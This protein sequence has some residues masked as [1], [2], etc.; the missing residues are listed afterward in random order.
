MLSV[1][2]DS[3]PAFFLLYLQ[4]LNFMIMQKISD[5]IYSVGVNDDDKVLFEGLWPLPYGVSYNS[6]VVADEKVALIDTVEGGFEDDFLDN[7]N[8]AIGDRPIDYLIVNHMV[9]LKHIDI[10][11]CCFLVERISCSSIIKLDTTIF[12]KTS[13]FHIFIDLI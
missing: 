8:E 12:W 4:T 7:I 11:Y 2:V 5:R 13:F 3:Q 6:Y 9:Q 1:P 10:T